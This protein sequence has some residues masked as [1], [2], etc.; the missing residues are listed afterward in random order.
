MFNFEKISLSFSHSPWYF[1]LFLALLAGYSFYVYQYTIPKISPARK[2]FLSVLRATALALLLLLFFEPV[3]TLAKMNIIQPV[4]L[5]FLDNSRS[6][7]INDGSNRETTEKEFISGLKQNNLENNSKL[8]IFGSKLSSLKYDSLQKLNFNEGSTNFSQIFSSINTSD[9]NIASIVLVSDGVITDGNDPSSMATK[10]GIPIYTIGLGD[11][12]A[13]NDVW[14]KN[15]L[16]NNIIYAGAPTTISAT[17]SNIG[18]A[19]QNIVATLFEDGNQVDKQNILLS[20]EGFQNVNFAYTPKT[21]GEKKLTVTLSESKGEFTYANNK[22]IFYVNVLSNKVKILILSGS[23]SVDLSFIRNSLLSDTNLTV[24]AYIQISANQFLEK[25]FAQKE[26]DSANIFFLI[27]FPAKNTP[28]E[29]FRKVMTEITQND[30]PFLIALSSGVDFKR[31][32]ELQSELGFSYNTIN[33]DYLEVQ[34]DISS[35][36]DNNPLLQNNSDNVIQAWNNLP[37][38]YQPNINFNSKPESEILSRIKINNVPINKPLIL[39]RRLGNKKSISILAKDIWRWKLGTAPKN[40]DLFDRFILSSVKWLNAKDE[41]KQVTIKT[42]KKVYSLG[43][44]VDFTAQVYDQTFNPISDADVKVGIKGGNSNS[45]L[46]LNSIGNGLYTGSFQ[47]NIAGDYKYYGEAILDGK[48]IGSDN[49]N[50]NLGEV[51]IE[52]I[53]PRMNYDFLNL[54]SNNSGGKFY[55][56]KNYDDI[57]Q[58][59]KLL[60]KNSSKEKMVTREV[61]LWSDS[62]LLIV[63]IILFG[64]EWFYRKKWGM[65]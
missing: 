27:G 65:L 24:N 55:Y 16:S 4:N 61:Y 10:L 17:V 40:L 62:W 49:G 33:S 25:D 29:L 60:D 18:F 9:N 31:L 3:L 41:N 51:D 11:T 43:E 44:N 1:F 63:A 36:E 15:V 7:Q 13:R 53:N 22:K 34:P 8:F 35:G 64:T 48:K 26:I 59:L 23:P 5:I 14:I 58:S 46:I 28:E 12:T 50:F 56:N 57:Y 20:G 2:I 32:Q 42:S 37:P 39:M 52:M 6:I 38:V 19:N 45:L 30:K 21:G 47:S 54:L